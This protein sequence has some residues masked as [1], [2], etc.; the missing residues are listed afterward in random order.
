MNLGVLIDGE[1]SL[2]IDVDNRG[3]NYGDGL[4]EDHPDRER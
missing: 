4:F 2:R 1:Q 3:L